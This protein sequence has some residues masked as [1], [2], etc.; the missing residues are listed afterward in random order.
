MAAR[1]IEIIFFYILAYFGLSN[2]RDHMGNAQ[3]EVSTAD[4]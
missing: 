1:K 3:N 4:Y 2:R